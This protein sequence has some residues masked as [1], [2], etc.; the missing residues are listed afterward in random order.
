[1]DNELEKENKNISENSEE[2]KEK[3]NFVADKNSSKGVETEAEE[4]S[5]D[6]GNIT[7][8]TEQYDTNALP[9][10]AEQSAS[11]DFKDFTESDNI[12][13]ETENKNFFQR[14]KEKELAKEKEKQERYEKSEENMRRVR[15]QRRAELYADGKEPNWLQKFLMSE[16]KYINYENKYGVILGSFV[17]IGIVLFILIFRAG[18]ITKEKFGLGKEA[19]KAIVYSKDNELYCYD[20]K[21]DPV[22]I[23]ENLS[24]GGS[25]TYSY[26]GNGTRVAEDGTSVYFIDNVA[27]DGTFS[28]NFYDAKKGGEPS[29]ISDRV[30]D[31][32]IS[33]K[34]EGAVYVVPDDN[35]QS[36]TLYGYSRKADSSYEISKN[37]LIG[38]MEYAISGDGTKAIYATSEGKSA[39]LNISGIDGTGA[40]EID[41]E[42]A[43]YLVTKMDKYL[44]YIKSVENAD[45]SSGY[46]I[47]SFDMD[48]GESSLIDEDII[49]VALSSNENSLIYYKYNGKMIKAS[50]I[51]NDDGDGSEADNA[52]REAAADYEFKDITCSAYRYEAGSSKLINDNVFAALTMDDDGNFIAYTVPRG[53]NKIRVNLSEITTVNEISAMY[54]MEAMQAECDTYVYKLNGFD[55]YVM[56]EDSYIYSFMNSANNAQFGCFTNYDEN[57]KRGTFMLSTFNESGIK[58]YSELEDDVESFRF[59]GDGSRLAY[60]RGVQAD[61]SGTLIYIE[62]NI[63]DEVSDSAYYYEVSEDL[64]RRIFYLDEYD[65]ATLG[66]TFHYY[67]QAV[68]EIVDEN[69]YMFAYRKNNNCLYMKNYDTATGKG[70]LYYLNGKKSVLVDSG[71]DSVFDFYEVG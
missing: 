2:V 41:T 30:A 17:I 14:W 55:D 29:L 25:V 67:Q 60:L 71:V 16:G 23:S 61:G 62:S 24:S 48:R 50:D 7:R 27:A 4:E 59:L 11:D 65:S 33:Y 45:G 12:N 36:G 35:E 28:L 53:L 69:V 68:D 21:N 54:Y 43:Q 70:D 19:T 58:S 5:T 46:N 22:L 3:E 40:K 1:M 63:A 32:E 52:L 15:E 44:Y 49:A 20:L 26:V 13:I 8:V 64:Y 56:F 42:V 57:A 39:A 31:Y 66:G 37:V 47:Y 18:F 10:E 38:G 51:L 9:E 34:G 6:D